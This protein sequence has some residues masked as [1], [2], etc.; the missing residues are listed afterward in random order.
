[1][2]VPPYLPFLDGPPDFAPKLSP[3][4]EE[5]WL[6][7]DTEAAGWIEE[8]REIMVRLR[9]ETFA[10]MR[11]S[12]AAR[13]EASRM[14]FA[15]LK[16]D[17]AFRVPTELEDAAAHLSDDLCIIQQSE[18]GEWCLTAASLCAPTYWH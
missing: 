10:A 6:L 4:S 3:I 9:A 7:P 18:D 8:K 16:Q 5:R 15:H 14:I 2:R 11:G 17:N 12:E 1:M 13:C